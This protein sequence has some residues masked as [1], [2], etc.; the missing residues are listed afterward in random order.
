MINI[1]EE[2]I[3][4]FNEISANTGRQIEKNNKVSICTGINS[5]DNMLKDVNKGSLIYLGGRPG[6]GKTAL[7]LEIAL[8]TALKSEKRVCIF[9]YEMSYRQLIYR[10]LRM[11]S[12][13]DLRKSYNEGTITYIEADRL[14]ESGEI[15]DKANIFI[16]DFNEEIFDKERYAEIEYSSPEA[17]KEK[18]KK[19]G[20]VD[21][22]II[23][24]IHLMSVN[25]EEDRKKTRFERLSKVTKEL[26]K[27][28]RDFNIPIICLGYLG[29][30]IESKKDIPNLDDLEIVD[31]GTMVDEADVIMLLYKKNYKSEGW[32]QESMDL[33]VCKNLFGEEGVVALKWDKDRLRFEDCLI[34]KDVSDKS[35]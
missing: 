23:D 16:E 20:N 5:L 27:L 19:M 30:N 33:N 34:D 1:K 2:L 3:N 25:W 10:M 17:I 35:E 13:V 12:G 32:T 22:I 28:S 6:V 9:S 8:E 29:R 11:L 31:L 18:I 7:A 24:Y 21:L 4:I 26:K 15:L 14:V